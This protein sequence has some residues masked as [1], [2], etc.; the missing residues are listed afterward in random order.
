MPT[1]TWKQTE[2]STT[3]FTFK[4]IPCPTRLIHGGVTGLHE[5]VQ[6]RARHKCHLVSHYWYDLKRS[7]CIYMWWRE[8]RYSSRK[9][10]KLL[11][12]FGVFALFFWG[13]CVCP[14][15]FQHG[16]DYLKIKR[17]QVA[18]LPKGL[19]WCQVP[20]NCGDSACFSTASGTVLWL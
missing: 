9:C 20:S 12:D 2:K 14:L 13:L 18:Q 10:S 11:T 6:T 16:R 15:N 5:G 19:R 3:R 4:V 8:S 7:I 17:K 1:Y